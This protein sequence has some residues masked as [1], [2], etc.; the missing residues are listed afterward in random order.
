M[1][2][3]PIHESRS[4]SEWLD[5]IVLTL[6]E[7]QTVHAVKIHLVFAENC[8]ISLIKFPFNAGYGISSERRHLWLTDP[9]TENRYVIE[10]STG[11]HLS[12]GSSDLRPCRKEMPHKTGGHLGTSR[13]KYT[14]YQKAITLQI[15]GCK[16][17]WSHDLAAY[18]G[19]RPVEAVA[20]DSMAPQSSRC[21]GARA[22][23]RILSRTCFTCLTS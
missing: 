2:E 7:P 14:C 3:R 8:D 19:A 20:N 9:T 6:L 16:K 13:I 15:S 22:S 4:R 10:S 21:T 5:A 23:A 11:D 18:N 12:W 17:K 1:L